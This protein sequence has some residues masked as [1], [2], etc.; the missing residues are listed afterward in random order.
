MKA[1]ETS[2]VPLNTDQESTCIKIF[3]YFGKHQ[4]AT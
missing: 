1:K 3:N 2:N 4:I